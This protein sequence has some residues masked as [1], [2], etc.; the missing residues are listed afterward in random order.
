MAALA[1]SIAGIPAVDTDPDLP[2][3]F[4][5]MVPDACFAVARGMS[6]TP[7]KASQLLLEPASASEALDGRYP[8]VRQWYRS[9]R[10][11]NSI[12]LGVGDA[13]RRCHIVLINTTQGPRAFRFAEALLRAIGFE[14]F[15]DPKGRA[16]TVFGKHAP[17]GTMIVLLRGL[18]DATDGIGPQVSFD[19]ALRPDRR[20]TPD[21]SASP[22]PR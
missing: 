18:T 11:P 20:A 14:T 13:P 1:L 21:G 4:F 22:L 6:L 12:L 16:E 15:T 10:K 19:V 3:I 9:V 2:A 8:A 7:D 17:G 5:N